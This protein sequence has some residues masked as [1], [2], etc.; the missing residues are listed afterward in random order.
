[1]CPIAVELAL[2]YV[3]S[4]TQLFNQQV[5]AGFAQTLRQ[6]ESGGRWGMWPV[7]SVCY[8]SRT[9]RLAAWHISLGLATDQ[10]Q[11]E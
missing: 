9:C 4:E 10:S 3:C 5:S 7:L 2:M 1:M 11:C 6:A 8:A